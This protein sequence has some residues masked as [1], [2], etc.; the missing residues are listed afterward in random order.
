MTCLNHNWAGLCNNVTDADA[1]AYISNAA[2][3]PVLRYG[4]NCI[5][6]SKTSK[7]CFSRMETLQAKQEFAYTNGR[8]VLLS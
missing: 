1:I 7:T 2:I 5:H 4:I 3:R 8:E 6:V